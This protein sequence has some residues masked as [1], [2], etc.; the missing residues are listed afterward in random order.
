M[1][2]VLFYGCYDFNDEW[3]LIEMQVN[4]TCDNID[5]GEIVVPQEDMKPGDWQ[6]AYLEQYLN[7]D[8]TERI[9]DLY[10]EPEEA[11]APCRVAFFIYK[12]GMP[13]LRTPYGDFDLT[14][15]QPVPER[16][17]GGVEMES[18]EDEE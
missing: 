1:E 7:E 16:L 12:I 14:D 6:C 8:G 10:D 4:E 18:D 13:V 17:V 15:P 11:V 9:C 2:K 3:L 5:W